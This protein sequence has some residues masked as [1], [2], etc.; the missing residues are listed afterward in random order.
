MKVGDTITVKRARVK[1]KLG[2]MRGDIEVAK[3]GLDYTD[4]KGRS[5]YIDALIKQPN[6]R[7]LYGFRVIKLKTTI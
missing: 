3:I 4:K 5:S 1:R 6:S 2:I 7:Y